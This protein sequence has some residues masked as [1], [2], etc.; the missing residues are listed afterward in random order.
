M[1][2]IAINIAKSLKVVTGASTEVTD[3]KVLTIAK[4]V[5][6]PTWTSSPSPFPPSAS[7]LDVEAKEKAA[8]GAE[9]EV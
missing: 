9:E 2:A 8:P 3:I 4:V 1:V 6:G 5:Q 7:L